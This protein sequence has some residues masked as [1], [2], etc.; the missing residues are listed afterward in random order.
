[1]LKVLIE[2]QSHKTFQILFDCKCQ[3]RKCSK[4]FS[5]FISKIIYNVQGKYSEKLI[6][7]DIRNWMTK[8]KIVLH[9]TLKWGQRCFLLRSRGINCC[10]TFD[11]NC[12]TIIRLKCW[13]SKLIWC[14]FLERRYITYFLCWVDM[15]WWFLG[16]QVHRPSPQEG[17]LKPWLYQL[18]T[19]VS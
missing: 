17:L 18:Q 3:L 8:L 10:F 2:F 16:S 11:I 4:H 19:E 1:M 12:I 14:P 9:L 13:Y 6:C 7:M 15:C 5:G